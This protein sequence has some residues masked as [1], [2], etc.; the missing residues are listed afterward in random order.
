MSEYL[1]QDSTLTDIANAIRGKDGTTE[2]I[3]AEEFAS[4]IENID[5]AVTPSISVSSDGLITATAGDKSA[6]KQL[7]TQPA[8]TIVAGES[9][10]TI[11][12]AGRY[13]TGNITLAAVV[14]QL[15]SSNPIDATATRTD[16]N[17]ISFDIGKNL[18]TTRPMAIF[19]GI[20]TVTSSK[21]IN[22]RN[23][24]AGFYGTSLDSIASWLASTSEIGFGYLINPSYDG[25]T[26]ILTL[27][28]PAYSFV[29]D[30]IYHIYIRQL[31]VVKAD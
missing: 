31:E 26:G 20:L 23:Y 15:S 25:T 28:S 14:G 7:T 22:S 19:G 16:A 21:T 13:T 5:A 3:P 27:N 30:V 17:N 11:V 2:A 1:I 29:S 6:T 9:T 8:K 18:S 10:Y 4:R 24:V 12:P